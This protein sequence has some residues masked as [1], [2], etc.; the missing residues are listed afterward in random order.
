M[1]ERKQK[2]TNAE[3]ERLLNDQGIPDHDLASKGGRIQDGTRYGSW[4][5]KHDKVQFAV[6]FKEWI[7]NK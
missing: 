5:R 2:Y 3:Y 1:T 6:E 4:L 7:G